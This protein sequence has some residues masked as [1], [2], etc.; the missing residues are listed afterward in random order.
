LKEIAEQAGFQTVQHFTRLFT[1]ME[2][3]S[4]AVWKREY[5][6]GIRKDVYI[7]PHFENRIFTV[8]A[9]GASPGEST[10]NRPEARKEARKPV[11][12]PA[13]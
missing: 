10:G 13:L 2:G 8:G 7:N 6:E 9:E 3:R 12:L 4:P 5:L 11:P 1:A